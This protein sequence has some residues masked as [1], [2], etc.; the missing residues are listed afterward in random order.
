M[1]KVVVE[2]VDAGTR[3]KVTY[4]FHPSDRP[5][6]DRRVVAMHHGILHSRDHFVG[7]I[8]ELN[9]RGIHVLMVDQQSE[10][11]SWR[12]F[13]GLGAYAKGL[14]AALRQFERRFSDYRIEAYIMHSMGAAIG[15]RMQ[16]NRANADLCRP[17][18]LMAPIP[19]QGAVGIFVRLV[20]SRPIGLGWAIFTMNVAS[21]V[22]SKRHVRKIF[23]DRNVDKKK[24]DACQRHLRHSPFRA[25]LQ[26]TF[27]YV[28]RYLFPQNHNGHPA[29][30]LTSRSDYI[31]R[32]DDA[33]NEY[34]ETE[35]FYRRGLVRKDGLPWLELRRIAGGHDFFFAHPGKAARRIT[36]FLG[37]LGFE[38]FEDEQTMRL[39]RI[40]LAEQTLLP[41]PHRPS[42]DSIDIRSDRDE[43]EDNAA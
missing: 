38:V 4:S 28:L 6:D 14:A 12:N 21:L 29:L 37:K 16:E 15:E 17:M 11:S 20:T 24:V 10:Y 7:L 13:I 36:S 22:R 35:I 8:R 23:F 9:H 30:I 1:S 40:D 32:R 3:L 31:F 5:T 25:Y 41:S 43:Q 42:G 18:V 2:N 34:R 39:R 27:R 26:L 33:V 19:I